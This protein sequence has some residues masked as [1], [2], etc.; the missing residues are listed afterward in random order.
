MNVIEI[1]R[2]AKKVFS[3][4]YEIGW[5]DDMNRNP[6]VALQLINTEIA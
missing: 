6:F 5:W 1:N 2:Y 3:Q 4:N